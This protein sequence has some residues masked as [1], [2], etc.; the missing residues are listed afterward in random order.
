MLVDTRHPVD[1][2]YSEVP[3]GEVF[4][5]YNELFVK[6]TEGGGVNLVN[7]IRLLFDTEME[8]TLVPG[9]FLVDL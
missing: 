7:G 2:T 8:V 6:D 9:R 4:G 3:F 1:V 5:A